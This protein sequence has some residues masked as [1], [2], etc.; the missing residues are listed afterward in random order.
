MFTRSIYNLVWYSFSINRVGW[1]LV[2]FLFY[3]VFICT[4]AL[5]DQEWWCCTLHVSRRP[6]WNAWI[7]LNFMPFRHNS[8]IRWVLWIFLQCM[9]DQS[10]VK[11][12][13]NLL[14]P[15]FFQTV[16]QNVF[17]ITPLLWG[18]TEKSNCIF[19]EIFTRFLY[20]LRQINRLINQL[21][22]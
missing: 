8:I 12:H 18:Y 21:I 9:K 15:R 20:N 2:N 16:A 19:S 17:E 14:S 3:Q 4:H 10:I 7:H 22:D 13:D 6:I 11:F 1:A 5:C